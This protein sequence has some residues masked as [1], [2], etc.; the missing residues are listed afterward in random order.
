MLNNLTTN[1]TNFAWDFGNGTTSSANSPIAN[2]ETEGHYKIELITWNGQNCADTS[3]MFYDLMFKGLYVPNAFSPGHFD[4]EVAVFKPKGINLLKYNIEIYDRSGNLLWNSSKL[5]G[6]GSPAQA[7]DGTFNGEVLKQGVYLWRISAQFRDGKYWEGD[8]VGN[9]EGIP[10][11][12]SGT[13]TLI[14]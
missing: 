7:W 14:R 11:T 5:D 1:G 3:I 13:I 2:F 8:S 10:Q 6:S 12:K 9:V 4:Q